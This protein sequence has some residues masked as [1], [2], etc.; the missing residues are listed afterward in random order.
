METAPLYNDVAYGPEG[1]A[2]HWVTASDG[3][4]IR[5]AHWMAPQAKGTVLVFPGRTEFIEKYGDAALEFTNAGYATAVI[6]WR[7]QGLADR[8]QPDRGLGYVRQFS[9]YQDDVTAMLDHVRALS[10]PEPYYLV[11]HSMGGCIGLRAL[12]NDLPV[13]AC[14]FSAPMWG[15]MM[16]PPTR[17]FAWVVTTAARALGLDSRI[18]PGQTTQNYTAITPLADNTL[19]SDPRMYEIMQEQLRKYPDLALGGPSMTWLNEALREMLAL[20]RMPSP[21]IPC[22]TFLG[23]DE[24]I[25]TP[26]RIHER[27]K[28]WPKGELVIVPD[29]RHEVML[30]TSAIRRTVYDRTIAH[31]AA[32]S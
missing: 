22:L 20:S 1:G 26:S 19:T 18:A 2:A 15:I 28:R 29:G 10:L 16:A 30:E 7:G 27:M 14:M 17:P 32:H 8:M 24:Q 4:R 3:V 31:F 9:D 6:D 25:V 12:L 13:K 11:G 23:T 5:V 21:D